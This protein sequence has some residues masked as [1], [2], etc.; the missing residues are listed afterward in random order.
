MGDSTT[1][2]ITGID[3]CLARAGRDDWST[4]FLSLV[5]GAGAAQVMVFSYQ[6]DHAACL[7]SRNFNARALGGALAQ[8]YL[9]GWF[10]TDPLFARVMALQPGGL[11]LT[12]GGDAVPEDYRSRFFDRPGLEGK[13]AVLAAGA[14]LRLTVNFYWTGAPAGDPPLLSLLGRL[15]LLHFEARLSDEPAALE[16]LS[17]REKAV[18]LGILAGR[19][20]EQIAADLGV[21]PSSVITYRRRAYDKLGISSRGA[22]FAICRG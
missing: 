22:L 5:E 6:P 13:T 18:C 17:E 8:E 1:D 4:P 20:A 7:L 9:D 14:R 16:V 19:K 3:A 11:D 12:A 10:R 21:A 2:L 15:A